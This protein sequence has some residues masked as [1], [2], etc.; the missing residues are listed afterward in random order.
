MSLEG[1][2]LTS[3]FGELAQHFGGNI[4]LH[5]ALGKLVILNQLV[6]FLF[7]GGIPIGKNHQLLKL[8]LGTPKVWGL[9]IEDI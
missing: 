2:V 6:Y 5:I 1:W 4:K 3:I 7:V 9:K 8:D